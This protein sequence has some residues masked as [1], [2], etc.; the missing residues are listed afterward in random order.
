MSIT[1]IVIMLSFIS[2]GIHIFMSE[3]KR[4][5]SLKQNMLLFLNA[6]CQD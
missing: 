6:S 2:Y 1:S 3:G 5:F 4:N